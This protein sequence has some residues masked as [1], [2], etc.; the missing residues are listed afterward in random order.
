M[1]TNAKRRYL[2]EDWSG[3]PERLVV[4]LEEERFLLSKNSDAPSIEESLQVFEELAKIGY[5]PRLIDDSNQ[6]YALGKE[7]EEGYLS[8]KNDSVTHIIEIA[9]PPIGHPEKIR[10]TLDEVWGDISGV[11]KKLNLNLVSNTSYIPLPKN[12]QFMPNFARKDWM[13]VRAKP[14]DNPFHYDLI[15][16]LGTIISTQVHLNAEKQ[17]YS[18]LSKLY[19]FEYLIPILFRNQ[20]FDTPAFDNRNMSWMTVF[21]DD[22]KAVGTPDVIPKTK[23]EYEKLIQQT[24][25]FQ[26]DYSLVVPR[27]TGGVEFRSADLQP[28]SQRT[29]EL[30][31]F[32]IGALV[33]SMK[34]PLIQPESS[35][36]EMLFEI[37]KKGQINGEYVRK[38]QAEL[39]SIQSRI[40]LP[41]M[42]YFLKMLQRFELLVSAE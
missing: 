9:L 4:G 32:R 28:D 34:F 5:S 13:K 12:A 23:T 11:T 30:I 33:A 15:Y 22:Y 40:P 16:F 7:F 29:L 31:A 39:E 27:K 8:I 10:E 2:I 42:P 6:I 20:I 24:R 25:D 19:E 18:I 36:K 38:L 35:L 21:P 41:W 14:S 17:I 37:Y 3:D 1:P 26:K